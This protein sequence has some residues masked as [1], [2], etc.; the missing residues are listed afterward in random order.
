MAWRLRVTPQQLAK[1]IQCGDGVPGQLSRRLLIDLNLPVFATATALTAGEAAEL[2]L[3]PWADRYPP[4][5]HSAGKIWTEGNRRFDEWLFHDDVRYCPDCLAGD[6]TAVQQ[7]Y[8]GPW[9]KIWHLPIAF[10]CP[11]HHT[12]LRDACPRQHRLAAQPNRLITPTSEWVLHPA[13]CRDPADPDGR[14]RRRPCC[15]ARLD[16]PQPP[17]FEP[18]PAVL[19]AQRRLSALLDPRTSPDNATRTFT[20]LRVVVSLLYLAWPASQDLLQPHSIPAIGEHVSHLNGGNRKSRDSLPRELH[21]TAAILTAALNVLDHPDLQNALVREIQE[22]HTIQPSKTP[23]ASVLDR[24]HTACSPTL[25]DTIEPAIRRYR[26]LA[27]PRGPKAPARFGGYRPEH[28][29]A[30]LEDVWFDRHLAPLGCKSRLSKVLRRSAAA[31]LV[32]WSAGGSLG[33]AANFLGI[34]PKGGQFAFT[35]DLYQWLDTDPTRTSFII[36][37]KNLA[38]ELDTTPGLIDYQHRRDALHGWSLDE[39]SSAFIW[40]RVTQGEPRFAPRPIEAQQPQH[41][42][43]EWLLRRGTTWHH[44]NR[45]APLA[46]YG[47]LKKLLIHEADLLAATTDL[48]SGEPA[49]RLG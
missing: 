39:E 32:Q 17:A 47:A 49:G 38:A 42:Q 21:A 3:L 30:F 41:T 7:A 5:T 35:K 20:D 16:Q 22:A 8:G 46:H 23:L 48:I 33:D 13:Q 26:R 31:I 15:G 34:N 25:R 12:F 24:H 43:R 2:T 29:P 27:G 19:N 1:V 14:G 36:A 28:V 37:L 18:R 45:E 6:G 10:A 44:L 11:D 9:K 4:I 40:A